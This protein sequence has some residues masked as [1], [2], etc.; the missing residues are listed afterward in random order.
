MVHKSLIEP[1][2]PD[3]PFH[4]NDSYMFSKRMFGKQNQFC[5]SKLFKLYPWLD[6]DEISDSVTYFVYKYHQSKLKVV[7]KCF[8]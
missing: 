2:F 1:R 7:Q 5:N 8:T 3:K 4:P 6:C